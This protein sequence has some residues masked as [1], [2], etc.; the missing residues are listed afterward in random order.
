MLCG[1]VWAALLSVV[2]FGRPSEP[3]AGRVS[4]A[5]G[6]VVNGGAVGCV[7][8]GGVVVDLG[9]DGADGGIWVIGGVGVDGG[10]A[11]GGGVE[12][13]GVVVGLLFWGAVAVV[14]AAAVDVSVDDGRVGSVGLLEGFVGWVDVEIGEPVFAAG[15]EVGDCWGVESCVVGVDVVGCW[16]VESGVLVGAGVVGWGF[17]G[18]VGVVFA[19]P[20]SLGGGFCCPVVVVG[21]G[22]VGVFGWVEE[23]WVGR[24]SDEPVGLGVG[25]SLV[26]GVLAGLFEGEASPDDGVSLGALLFEVDGESPVGGVA[27]GASL[28][29]LDGVVSPVGGDGVDPLPFGLDAVVSLGE[30][31]PLDEGA[32]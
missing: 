6:G 25:A 7:V 31:D 30:G 26:E 8:A 4:G 23:S 20:L 12:V 32:V 29:G 1:V 14:V 18:V 15:V 24:S 5:V 10:V 19:C 16:V 27:V 28:V 13:V 11:V 2:E 21:E 17:A 22:S 3:V 9:D